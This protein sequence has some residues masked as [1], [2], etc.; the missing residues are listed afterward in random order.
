[1]DIEAASV[2]HR[3]ARDGLVMGGVMAAMFVC[4]AAGLRVPLLTLLA[5]ALFL[6]VPFVAYRLMLAGYKQ[7]PA[8][9][10][11]ATVWMHGITFFICG[12][13]IL[14][15]V[16]YVYCRLIDPGFM[17]DLFTATGQALS[18]SADPA[19]A[20]LGSQFDQLADNGLLP[21]PIQ[22]AFSLLWLASFSGSLLSMLLAA[23]IRLI[24]QNKKQ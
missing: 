21:S 19:V 5:D 22:M 8:Q 4:Q 18:A 17:P 11:F 2:Y 13:L 3:G 20:E 7:Y 14:A 9:R 6:A 16:A 23:L 10:Q 15:V 12:S 1:M 24:N